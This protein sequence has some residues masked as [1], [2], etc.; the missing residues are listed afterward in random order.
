MLKFYA[1]V[2]S[3]AQHMMTTISK[4]KDQIGSSRPNKQ[5]QRQL[6]S[7][8]LQLSITTNVGK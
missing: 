8:Y 2:L 6:T 5:K 7:F 3:S 1:A 4:L